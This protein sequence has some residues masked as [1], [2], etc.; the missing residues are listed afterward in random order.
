VARRLYL[1]PDEWI[2]FLTDERVDGGRYLT[3]HAPL[4]TI[5]LYVHTGSIL[6]LPPERTHLGAAPEESITLELYPRTNG[7]TRTARV[8]WDAFG[9]STE[10]TLWRAGGRAS[11][12][13]WALA[14][15][16]PRATDWTVHWHVGPGEIVEHE[17]GRT[18][19]ATTHLG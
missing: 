13:T 15:D 19:R 5:P 1:P 10:L 11:G 4:D 7:A 6:A 2:D 12:G 18:A 14:L 9:T 3:R 16:G 8:V 17:V